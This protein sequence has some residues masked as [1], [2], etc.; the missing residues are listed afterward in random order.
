MDGVIRFLIYMGV[1]AAGYTALVVIAAVARRAAP[2]LARSRAGRWVLARR[3]ERRARRRPQRGPRPP[4]APRVELDPLVE[5]P[6]RSRLPSEPFWSMSLL[7]DGDEDA[8]ALRP[9][10]QL[11]GDPLPPRA[12]IRIEV[13]D[14]RDVV[15]L[16]VSRD[17]PPAALDADLPMPAVVPPGGTGA[18]EVLGWRWDV[19]IED[20]TGERA[21]WTEWL[22]PAGRLNAEA[23][24]ATHRARASSPEEV[25]LRRIFGQTDDVV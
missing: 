16:R 15:R 24:M 10:V 12:L 3:A 6:P 25:L 11:L 20:P 5:P 17:L 7:V 2:R 9:S 8:D 21:R 19:V 4:L 14:D 23:E 13:R 18:G 1:W 22:T